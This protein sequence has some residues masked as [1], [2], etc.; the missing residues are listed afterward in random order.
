MAAAMP[1][2]QET[3]RQCILTSRKNETLQE[4]AISAPGISTL[5]E[6]TSPDSAQGPVP[7]NGQETH[8]GPTK[9]PSSL[10]TTANFLISKSFSGESWSSYKNIFLTYKQFLQDHIDKAANP[11]SHL[12]SYIAH[13][14]T[15][16]LA[17]S[18]ARIHISAL[19]LI[20]QLGGHQDLTQHFIIKKHL[21]C[22]SNFIKG[23]LHAMYVL[24]LSAFLRVG[25]IT[26]TGKLNQH[27]LLVKHI[28]ITAS[29]NQEN[30]IDLTIPHCK[31]SI[32]PIFLQ[33]S[34]NLENPLLCP[35]RALQYFMQIRKHASQNEA[36]F[37]F[38]DGNPVSHRFFTKNLQN[39]FALCGLD[40]KRYQSHS[41]RI[42]AA[43]AAA[44]LGP[45]DIHIQTW[46]VGN[47]QLLKNT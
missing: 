20:F 22:Y 47:Q 2:V 12:V 29:P 9:H 24:T 17:A 31:H 14:F 32:R 6:I 43:T 26:K 1:T 27:F 46:A 11:L 21:Q 10:M 5:M 28:N 18:T 19:S 16:G 7:Q 25:E 3:V 13:F 40:T 8:G 33:I 30:S 15:Q 35:V 37:S 4:A 42:G 36:L 38:M 44:D 23:L 34:R 39:S 41:F 45:S